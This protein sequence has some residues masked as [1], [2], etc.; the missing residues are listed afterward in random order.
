[1]CVWKQMAALCAAKGYDLKNISVWKC[2]VFVCSHGDSFVYS[3]YTLKCAWRFTK[4]LR[5]R[6]VL[7]SHFAQWKCY[8]VVISVSLFFFFFFTWVWQLIDIL[9]AEERVVGFCEYI[10]IIQFVCLDSRCINMFTTSLT[11]P[12]WFSDSGTSGAAR[13]FKSTTVTWEPLT[14]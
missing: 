10:L 9:Q 5:L 6:D 1:M 14:P 12:F 13:W 2:V 7:L 8:S 3:A 11:L 4:C